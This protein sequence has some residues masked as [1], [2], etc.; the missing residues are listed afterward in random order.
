MA[1]DRVEVAEG[2]K[3]VGEG[4]EGEGGA[5][6][7]ESGV[8]RT[9]GR[10]GEEGGEDAVGGKRLDQGLRKEE[11]EG[12]TDELAS[13]PLRSMPFSTLMLLFT[14]P[15]PFLSSTTYSVAKHSTSVAVFLYS[16]LL[17]WSSPLGE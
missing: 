12:R 16:A 17:S 6:G 15:A 11:R 14:H 7:V 1:V 8:A 3:D 13:T 4:G 9:G 2:A 5:G 10:G